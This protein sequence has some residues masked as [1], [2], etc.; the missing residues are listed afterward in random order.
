MLEGLIEPL[1]RT[2][3]TITQP[4]TGFDRD[5][6][7]SFEELFLATYPRLVSILRRML[8][9]CGRAEE[10]A[11]E[12]FLKL[13][14]AV[15]PPAAK[16][17]LPGW[18]YRTAMN[19]GID[20]LRARSRHF[21]LTQR[22]SRTPSTSFCPDDGLQ[23]VLRAERQKRVR[24]VLSR[25]KP[26]SAQLLLLRAT[27]HSYREIAAHLE[28]PGSSVGT[29]LLRAEAAFEKCYVELFGDTD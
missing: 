12:A 5:S 16:K 19:L 14:T 27:G 6:P 15:L 24:A 28:I 26:E 11:N 22:A 29:M 10:L 18:L 21:R 17:N 3:P 23:H 8:G 1:P 7:Q 9:D 4:T 20:D 13:H 2:A 25:L